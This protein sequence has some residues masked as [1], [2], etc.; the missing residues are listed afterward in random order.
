M[1]RASESGAG[2]NPTVRPMRSEWDAAQ[3]RGPRGWEG[4]L[5]SARTSIPIIAG[6]WL[7]PAPGGFVE[8]VESGSERT[9]RSNP[10]RS[11]AAQARR[12]SRARARGHQSR[13]RQA[14]RPARRVCRNWWRAVAM[15]TPRFDRFAQRIGTPRKARRPAGGAPKRADINPQPSAA[16][17]Y[18]Q[19]QAGLSQLV[20]SGSDENPR[21]TAE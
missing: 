2:W 1:L 17:G 10:Q 7:R 8:L 3:R 14:L 18:D 16:R 15:R 6:T 19:H 20:E 4:A 13:D 11:D 21:S 9:P 5:R 12:L